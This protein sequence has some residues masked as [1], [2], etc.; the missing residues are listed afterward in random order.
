MWR[1]QHLAA[2]SDLS[3]CEAAYLELADRFKIALQTNAAKLKAASK[4][5]GLRA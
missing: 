4:Q 5:L 3:A 1:I 2:Q